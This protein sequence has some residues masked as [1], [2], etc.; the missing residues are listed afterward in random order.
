MGLTVEE[1]KFVIPCSKSLLLRLF[2]LSQASLVSELPP[3]IAAAETA[4]NALVYISCEQA[5]KL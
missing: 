4:L 3:S 5:T 1:V 2:D